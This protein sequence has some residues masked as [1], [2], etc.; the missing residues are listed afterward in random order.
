MSPI[1]SPPLP[2]PRHQ[3]EHAAPSSTPG[4]RHRSFSSGQCAGRRSRLHQLT[5]SHV[6]PSSKRRRRSSSAA[7]SR[8]PSLSPR[9]RSSPLLQH[10]EHA[11][12]PRPIFSPLSL[13]ASLWLASFFL[14]CRCLGS[15]VVDCQGFPELPLLSGDDLFILLFLRS[16][17]PASAQRHVVSCQ[18]PARRSLDMLFLFLTFHSSTL[19]N[20][21]K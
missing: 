6:A 5:G 17:D 20:H 9:R 13:S 19:K 15:T 2:R 18:V 21:I 10:R 14:S 12:S 3:P 1:G 8:L 16:V 11:V 4:E 7:E